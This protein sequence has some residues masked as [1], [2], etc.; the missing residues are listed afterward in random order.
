MVRKIN[1]DLLDFLS[2]DDIKVL[3]QSFDLKWML[4]PFKQ[5]SKNYSKYISQLGRLD[6]RS[7]MVKK[8]LPNIVYKLYQKKDINICIMIS[9][10]ANKFREDLLDILKEHNITINYFNKNDVSEIIQTLISINNKKL[11]GFDIELFLVQLKMNGV[12]VEKDKAHELEKKWYK[13]IQNKL[14]E[15]Q[16]E[17]ENI[18]K[19]LESNN[20]KN[21]DSI[22]KFKKKIKEIEINLKDK[23]VQLSEKDIEIAQKIEETKTLSKEL[24]K[25]KKELSDD[26]KIYKEQ[27]KKQLEDENIELMRTNE[28]LKNDI[29]EM[30]DKIQI[31]SEEFNKKT[32]DI[33]TIKNEMIVCSNELDN[34]KRE[35]DEIA[36]TQKEKT[37]KSDILYVKAGDLI[38]YVEPGMCN[39]ANKVYTSLEKYKMSIDT[40]L[41]QIGCKT[42]GEDL[43][44]FFDSAIGVG[45][46]PM[47]CGY[48]A[49]KMAMGLVA[50]RYGEIPTIISI[51]AGYKD[52]DTLN[53]KINNAETEVIVVEDLFGKMNEEIILP[54]LRRDIDK[55]LLFCCESLECMK[56]VAK[57]F[58]NY[59]QILV[60]KKV[61]NKKIE[62][63]VF[64]DARDIFKNIEIGKK[65][66]IA[67]KVKRILKN[68]DMSDRYIQSR[69]DLLT[70]VVEIMH[71]NEEDALKFWFNS[72]LKYILDTNQ[73][74][75]VLKNL[76]NN[77]ISESKKLIGILQI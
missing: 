59:I 5:N 58:Y 25:Y 76:E 33:E 53:D 26:E 66:D 23:E 36:V 29:C 20:R 18:K 31:L 70:Y 28:Q 71:Q 61:S 44:D 51:P 49:R 13:Y 55:Q 64:S 39:T 60:L 67:K 73:K 54:I 46:I 40:N 32:K 52:I 15:A 17:A 56:Y 27:W 47:L 1:T 24:E 37:V 2:D 22:T 43:E 4:G 75:Q 65:A 11:Y 6:S 62:T 63:F 42:D 9:V 48:G 38:L 68:T 19:I 45:L 30:T 10:Y 77:L 50:A 7:M 21:I 72:E 41:E 14:S 74:E 57:Y 3:I 16:K 12:V 34:K 35:I 69:R 8:N